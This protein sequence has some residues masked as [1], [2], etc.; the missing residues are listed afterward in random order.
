MVYGLRSRVHG[1]FVAGCKFCGKTVEDSV[2]L[3][4]WASGAEWPFLRH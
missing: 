3:Q 2:K 4:L 1:L